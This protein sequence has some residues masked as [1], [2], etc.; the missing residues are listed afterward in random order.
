MYSKINPET[1]HFR[2]ITEQD[3]HS[4]QGFSCNN[5]S[6]DSF[7]KQEA[8]FRHIAREASTT[9]FFIEEELVGYFTLHR[10]QIQLE[11]NEAGILQLL[12]NYFEN[13]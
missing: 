12:D 5:N 1:L 6:M 11:D 8:Y 13:P 3:H 2:T 4:C 9:L 7:L 10:K